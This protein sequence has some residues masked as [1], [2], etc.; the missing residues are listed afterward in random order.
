M[1]D[2]LIRLGWQNHFEQQISPEEREQLLLGRVGAHHGSQIL[3]LTCE[4]EITV[5]VSIVEQSSVSD[6][7]VGDWFLLEPNDHRAVRRL[8]RKTVLS[9][10]AAGDTV[11]PQLIA[12]N[13]DTVFIVSSCNEDFNPS[14]LERY[15]ALVLES[16]ATAVVVLTKADLS[17]DPDSLKQIA[18]ALHPGL[19][20]ETLDARDEHQVQ[21]LDHWCGPGQTVALVGSSGVGKSTLANALGG[22]N[23]ATQGIREDDAKGRHTTTARSMHLL[24]AG[25]WLIDNPGMR[26]LQ[27]ADCEQGV[28]DLFDDIVQLTAH[29]RFRNC[30]HRGDAGCAL[31]E[32][33]DSGELEERRLVNYLKLQ[34]EQARNSAT[35][36]ERR[37]RDRKQGRFYKSVIEGKKKRRER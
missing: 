30:S 13:V 10:K 20:V 19:I 5:P 37:E 8:D 36:A 22:H 24:H 17:D 2:D 15:L 12:A 14:R 26:E 33:V 25:G 3:F 1:N 32:A 23:I 18:S 28:A 16:E 29:C 21:I 4:S 6:I 7:A 35:L 34:N 9:R 11:K 31:E 27:L